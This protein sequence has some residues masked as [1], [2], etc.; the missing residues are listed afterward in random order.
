MPAYLLLDFLFLVVAY[1]LDLERGAESYEP[2]APALC[3]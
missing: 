1:E 2:P 3:I